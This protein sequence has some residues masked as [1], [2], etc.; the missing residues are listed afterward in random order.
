MEIYVYEV[1]W[2]E[3]LSTFPKPGE[4]ATLC[5]L[6]I[7]FDYFGFNA[8]ASKIYGKLRGKMDDVCVKPMDYL[9]SA[10]CINGVPKALDQSS[11]YRPTIKFDKKLFPY[12]CDGPVIPRCS[13]E[14]IAQILESFE[15]IPKGV[16]D[17]A[18][19]SHWSITKAEVFETPKE[20]ISY[21]KN[22][23]KIL[24]SLK[25]SGKGLAIDV[26]P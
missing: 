14:Q 17:S 24:K 16:L 13:P 1:D 12:G 10:I 18:I 15:A 8:E 2:N 20:F 7:D 3:F 9:I 26:D 11:V 6:Q 19:K 22:W 4:W 25:K 5:D 23:I 21:I